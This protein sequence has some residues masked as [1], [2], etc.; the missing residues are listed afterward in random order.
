MK[1]NIHK[2]TLSDHKLGKFE[3]GPH[4]NRA[5]NNEEEEALVNYI[6][7][8]VDHGFPLTR[9][10]IKCLALEII[11]E[12][13][14]HTLVNLEKGPSD[15]LWARFKAHHPKLTTRTLDSL[16]RA[17][18]LA[19]TPE[20]IEKFFILYENIVQ[21]YSLQDKPHLIWNCDETGFGDKPKSKEKVMCQRG[22]RRVPAADHDKGTHNCAPSGHCSG[23]KCPSFCHISSMP[24]QHGICLGWSPAKPLWML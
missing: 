20:A 4:P 9:T 19:A 6:V 13:S 17:R 18:V 22:K 11:K 16:D 2:S 1:Y 3:C 15:N 14:Q 24:S 12:R 5:I 10:I 23:C 7:R 8:M 21:K